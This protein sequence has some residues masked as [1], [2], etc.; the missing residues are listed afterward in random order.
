MNRFSGFV[1][2]G[3]AHALTS[4]AGASSPFQGSYPLATVTV[5]LPSTLTLATIYSDSSGTSRPNPFTAATDGSY[6]FYTNEPL[7]D[8]TFSGGGLASSFTITV[9]A[10][11]TAAATFEI[12]VKA[13]PYLA[14]G[15]GVVDDTAAILAAI[16]AV[17]ATG[18][19]IV[20]PAGTYKVAGAGALFT[21]ATKG[22]HVVGAG[23]YATMF[24]LVPSAAATVFT[25]SAGAAILYGCSIEGCSFTSA[26]TLFTKTAISLIDTSGC[27]VERCTVG[28]IGSWTKTSDKSSIGLHA[29][30]RD[31]GTVVLCSF[32]ADRPIVVSPNPNSFIDLDLWEFSGVI[33]YPAATR[34]GIEI[35]DCYVSNTRFVRI[36]CDGGVNGISATGTLSQTSTDNT[37]DDLRFEQGVSATGYAVKWAL[38]SSAGFRLLSSAAGTPGRGFL[39]H[40]VNGLLMERP[41]YNFTGIAFD[42]VGCDDVDIIGA[43]WQGGSSSVTTGMR[44]TKTEGQQASIPAAGAP[45]EH[46]ISA[47]NSN[48]VAF[49]MSLLDEFRAGDPTGG[50]PL[51]ANNAQAISVPGL[52]GNATFGM[53]Y[54]S[55]SGPADGFALF[56]FTDTGLYPI[57]GAANLPANIVV[58]IPGANHYGVQF[59]AAGNI[60]IRNDYAT[61]AVIRRKVVFFF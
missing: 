35:E 6:F 1:E 2:R 8:I 49:P 55:F 23:E 56:G 29:F 26:D 36:S 32:A 43:Q 13:F 5:Y 45:T 59:N 15:D 25:F 20:I 54:V 48:S 4:L 53:F 52:S 41:A 50:V 30:G 31:L 21:I 22:T 9:S 18:G 42:I 58:G 24:N 37:I 39:L 38:G 12:N 60:S 11:G 44:R 57:G 3:N 40:A 14:I 10:S 16:A 17:P 28:P 34:D 27:R 7:V 61:D 19:R 33:C 51:L 47:A 46:W